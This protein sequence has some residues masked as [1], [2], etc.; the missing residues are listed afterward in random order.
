MQ[1]GM[2]LVELLITLAMVGVLISFALPTY[3]QQQIKAYRTAGQSLLLHYANTQAEFMLERGEYMGADELNMR[4][5]Q[6]YKFEVLMRSKT[7]FILQA[8][9][10]NQ[11][12]QDTGCEVMSIDQSMLRLPIGCW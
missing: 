5:T 3:Q 8:T 11:Q 7:S 4:T 6:R 1:K 12:S 9:A 10:Q 2:S